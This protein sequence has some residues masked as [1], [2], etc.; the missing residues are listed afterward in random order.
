M[1]QDSKY[2]SVHSRD[3]NY[4]TENHGTLPHVEAF[5]YIVMTSLGNQVFHEPVK[6]QKVRRKAQPPVIRD[7]CVVTA[8]WTTYIFI[9]IFI[10]I[11]FIFLLLF[12]PS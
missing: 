8:C 9:L 1:V 6:A 5:V 11:I 4:C 12:F 3:A 7:T 2:V 10:F